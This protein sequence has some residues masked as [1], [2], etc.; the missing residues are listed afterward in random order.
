NTGGT[1]ASNAS[2]SAAVSAFASA[3][4]IWDEGGGGSWKVWGRLAGCVGGAR[5]DSGRGD[6]E[7]RG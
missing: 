4:G 5:R 7:G 6:V 2:A 1:A 3:Y